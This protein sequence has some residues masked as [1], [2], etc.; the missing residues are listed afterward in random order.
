MEMRN[1]AKL[2]RVAV[3]DKVG[4]THTRA[5]VVDLTEQTVAE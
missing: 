1:P 3:G 5:F 4:I 2:E